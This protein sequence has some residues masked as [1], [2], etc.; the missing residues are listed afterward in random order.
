[1]RELEEGHLA[2]LEVEPMA[3][4]VAVVAVEPPVSMEPVEMHIA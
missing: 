1:L 3:V 4:A 2:V